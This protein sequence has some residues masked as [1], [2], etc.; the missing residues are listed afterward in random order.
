MSLCSNFVYEKLSR[1]NKR[2]QVKI[3]LW[4]AEIDIPR[5][6]ILGK[7]FLEAV[8]PYGIQQDRIIIMVNH[9][10]ILLEHIHR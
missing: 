1:L 10:A 5:S 3:K 9:Q 6:L 2:N 4:I 7:D 8:S